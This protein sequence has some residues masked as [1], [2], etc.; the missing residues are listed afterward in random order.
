MRVTALF[1]GCSTP[2][3]SK[4]PA[5]RSVVLAVAA[6][7]ALVGLAPGA[8]AQQ[9][10]APPATPPAAQPEAKPDEPKHAGPQL[11]RVVEEKDGAIVRMETVTRT[12]K[13]SD[14]GP[15]VHL[16]GVTHIGDR[17]Y[18]DALQQFLNQQSI[19]LFEGVKPGGEGDSRGVATTDE[20][21][22]KLTERRL[23]LLGILI[24][25]SRREK[26]ALPASLDELE[27]SLP[28]PLARAFHGARSDGWSHPIGFIASPDG[29]TFD[30][31]SRGSDDAPGGEGFAADLNLSQQKPLSDSEVGERQEGIQ[32]KLAS[33]LGLEFQ[34]AAIDY[35][36]ANWRNSDMSIDQVQR[37]LQEAGAS[38]EQLFRMLDG[39]SMMAKFAGFLLNF[40]KAS[41]QMQ[42]SVKLMMMEMLSH[43][44]ELM[45]AQGGEQGKL[46]SVIVLDRNAAVLDDLK[47]ILHNEKDVESVALF[48]GAGHLPDLEK[49]LT[50]DFGYRF[51]S[52]RWF[53]AISMEVAKAGMSVQQARQY[54]QMM[55]QMIDRQKA[56]GKKKPK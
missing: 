2:A 43:A 32:T 14:A 18:Y 17:A 20:E 38:G 25:Q 41:P 35:S 45:E 21:R 12:F 8:L 39:S 50:Q 9:D 23:R 27:Q 19:V 56:T 15:I 11:T 1:S 6:S 47:A 42:S 51:E 5:F 49:H 33:A 46:M 10:A 54:R 48:Y 28:R 34:L 3:L 31:T 55:T 44:D 40:I 53:P 13:S 4:R 52:E 24:E 26:K 16:V 36:K 37:K 30:L 22:A 29:A 7:I